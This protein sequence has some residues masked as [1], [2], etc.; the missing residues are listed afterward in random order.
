MVNSVDELLLTKVVR[1]LSFNLDPDNF[2]LVKSGHRQK[3]LFYRLQKWKYDRTHYL[4]KIFLCKYFLIFQLGP[5]FIRHFFIKEINKLIRCQQG[6][7]LT[8]VFRLT[9][10]SLHTEDIV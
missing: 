2:D 9:T 10:R 7:N 4:L 6:T 1:Q 8:R 3:T 5:H